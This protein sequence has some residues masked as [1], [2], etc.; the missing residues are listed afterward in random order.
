MKSADLIDMLWYSHNCSKIF[1]VP[2]GLKLFNEFG[3][4]IFSTMKNPTLCLEIVHAIHKSVFD[5]HPPPYDAN[6]VKTILKF[7][8]A[9]D[10]KIL[11]QAMGKL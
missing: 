10:Y 9:K 4:T 3:M 1:S 6:D 11:C 7:D 5:M 2:L 8:I